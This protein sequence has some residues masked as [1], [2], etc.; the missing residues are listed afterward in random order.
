MAAALLKI[1]LVSPEIPWNVGAIGRTSLA[2]AAE[3]IIIKPCM[4]DLSDKAVKRAGLDYWEHVKLTVYDDWDAFV[5]T[6]KPEMDKLFFFSTRSS[7]II[8]EAK[9][10]PGS[11]LIFGA[12]TKGLPEMY[13]KNYTGRFFKLPIY[14]ANIR[15]L[16]L[17]NTVTAAAY[18]AIRQINY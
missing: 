2:V 1:V 18:E 7:S 17:A 9:F 8:Y 13:H 11:Y 12:E 6:Q 3:L 5:N 15:S 14:D 10:K 16:N 4:V